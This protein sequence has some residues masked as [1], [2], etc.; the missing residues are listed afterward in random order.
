[1]DAVRRALLLGTLLAAAMVATAGY[2]AASAPVHTQWSGKTT[3]VF[4]DAHGEHPG[5]ADIL[6][7]RVVNDPAAQR[8]IVVRVRLASVRAG[9][10]VLVWLDTDPW[11]AGPEHLAG[12]IANSDAL[13]VARVPGWTGAPKAVDCPA[14]RMAYD[15]WRPPPEAV[16]RVPRAC[17]GWPGAVR[18]SVTSR[19]TAGAG[20]PVR[21]FAPAR[22]AF[23]G[24]VPR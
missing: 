22:H 2:E 1:M 21:D 19:R 9:D 15:Q 5:V 23:Y 6:R 12:G 11:H 10:G 13:G 17:V 8:P 24:W 14:F 4:V 3:G 20:P 16:L 7:V 18:V